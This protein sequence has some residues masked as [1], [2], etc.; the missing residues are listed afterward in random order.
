MEQ[1]NAVEAG[2]VR[3][4]PARLLRAEGAAML[5]VAVVVFAHLGSPWWLFLALI[6]LPDLSMLGYAFGPAAG[7]RAYNAAHT[8]L[9]PAAL[10]RAGFA[11]GSGLAVSLALIWL[12]H[13]GLDRML[14]HGLKHPAGFGHTHLG[15]IGRAERVSG[16]GRA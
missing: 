5:L 7:A 14:G 6:L 16:Q 13:V 11:A 3:G 15:R 12:A 8:T 2:G 9:G 4:A 1:S 10:G